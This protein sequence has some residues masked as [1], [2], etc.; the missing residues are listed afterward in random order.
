MVDALAK[1]EPSQIPGIIEDLDDLAWWSEPLLRHDL[2]AEGNSRDDHRRR[3]HARL[4]LVDRDPSQVDPLVEELLTGKVTYV[5]PIRQML[6]PSAVTLTERFGEVLRNDKDPQRRFRA[7]LALA[8]YVPQSETAFWTNENFNFV[9]EQLVSSNAEYQP[10]LR[11]ALRPI[12]DK[13]MPDLK[14]VFADAEAT[15]A[16]RLSAANAFADYA[17]SDAVTL[18]QLLTVATPDQF[19]VLYPLVAASPSPSAVEELANKAAALPPDDLGFVERIA[20]GQHRANAAVTLVRLGEREKVLPVFNYT[21][22]PEALTQFIFRCRERGVGTEPLLELLDI[23]TRNVSE[24]PPP[25]ITSEAFRRSAHAR[26]ALLLA[27]GEFGLEEI[28]E[29]RRKPLLEQLADWYANDP[30]SGVHGAAGWLLRQWGQTEVAT[31]VDQTPVAYSP[32]R[33]WFT[34]AIS[35]TP[36]PPPQPS[37]DATEEADESD[38]AAADDQDESDRDEKTNSKDE[39]ADAEAN[40]PAKESDAEPAPT[41]TFYYTFIVF[42]AEDYTIGAVEASPIGKRTR[43]GMRSI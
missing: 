41:K 43:N 5:L 28:P 18:L 26:Y 13:L 37:D 17:A 9:A 35:V 27:L 40:E 16:Q 32:D 38:A 25:A 7:A 33:E 24:G 22:D 1:A 36:T 8:D 34:L 12:R 11:E 10:L 42:P 31:R 20:Y 4:A 19:A 15:D 6:R 2:A 30:S 29:T 39:T 21:D 23:E 3:L 14:R